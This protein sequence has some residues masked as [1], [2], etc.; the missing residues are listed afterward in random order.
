MESKACFQRIFVQ[1]LLKFLLLLFFLA[2]NKERRGCAIISAGQ[3][4]TC[5]DDTVFYRDEYMK[6]TICY[7]H[8]QD[9]CNHTSNLTVLPISGVLLF[10]IIFATIISNYDLVFS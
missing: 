5:Q 1:I 2:E 8:N 10:G 7:C 9:L 6:G 4:G 3:N